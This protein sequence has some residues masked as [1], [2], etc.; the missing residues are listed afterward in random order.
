[1]KELTEEIAACAA[2]IVVEEGAEYALAK[3]RA[4]KELGLSPANAPLPSNEQLESEV[5]DYLRLFC[6]QTQ[7]L[8]LLALRETALQWM[9]KLEAFRPHLSGAV[10]RGSATRLNDI[11]IQ[12]FCDDSKEAEIALLNQR[13][14]FDVRVAQGFTGREVD[15]LSLSEHCQGLNEA[16]GIHLLIY[17]HDDLRGALA[18]PGRG[19]TKNQLFSAEDA[20]DSEVTDNEGRLPTD[21]LDIQF[22]TA[23]I[24]T[25]R[26]VQAII[27]ATRVALAQNTL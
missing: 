1:M 17:D 22:T 11:Y 18:S 19:R 15:V 8:E 24:G 27:L 6:S 16:V 9:K 13:V 20:V 26:A 7:P 21:V 5:R 10:W 12:L 3:R 14:V 2:R 4:L 23:P 25:L